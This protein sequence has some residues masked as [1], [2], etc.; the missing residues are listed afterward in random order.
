MGCR[1]WWGGGVGDGG[2]GWGVGDD[3]GG[4]IATKTVHKTLP[5]GGG[6]EG[7]VVQGVVRVQVVVSSKWWRGEGNSDKNCT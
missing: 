3:G 4:G 1:G 6:G 7:V 5:G 2:V